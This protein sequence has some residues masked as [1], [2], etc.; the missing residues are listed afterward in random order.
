MSLVRLEALASKHQLQ[1][2]G[3]LAT[4]PEDD[5]GTGTLM[6]LGPSEPGF[7]SHV[8]AEPEFDDNAPDPLDRWSRRSITDIARQVGGRA[9][10]PFGLPHRPFVAWALRSGHA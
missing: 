1:N 10:F 7:W 4:T 9:Y 8:T 2:F 3:T 5:I 6:L